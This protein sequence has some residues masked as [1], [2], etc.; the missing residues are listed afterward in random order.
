M[1]S[2]VYNLSKNALNRLINIRFFYTFSL[3]F[4]AIL[5]TLGYL[6]IGESCH[7]NGQTLML[8]LAMCFTLWF[9]VR[10]NKGSKIGEVLGLALGY[11]LIMYF[12]IRVFIYLIGVPDSKRLLY[13]AFPIKWTYLEINKGLRFVVPALLASFIGLFLANKVLKLDKLFDFNTSKIPDLRKYFTSSLLALLVTY[14]VQ[15]YYFIY[16]G[17]SASTNCT[18]VNVPYKWLIHFFSSDIATFVVL[19]LTS[20][21]YLKTKEKKYFYYLIGLSVIFW[22][23]TILLGSRGGILRLVIYFFLIWAYFSNSF[24]LKIW[25]LSSVLLGFVVLSVLS[26]KVG[27][28]VRVQSYNKCNETKASVVKVE[29]TRSLASGTETREGFIKP[30]VSSLISCQLIGENDKNVAFP[31][32]LSHI[33]DRL[34]LIDIPVGVVALGHI[35]VEKREKYFSIPYAFKSFVNNI[36]PGSPF[37][38]VKYMSSNTLAVVYRGMSEGYIEENF[39]SDVMTFWGAAFNY[40]GWYGGIFFSFVLSFLAVASIYLFK[41]LGTSFA[42][43]LIPVWSWMGI[44]GFYLMNSYDYYLTI[45]VLFIIEISSF[46]VMTFIFLQLMKG[47][48]SLKNSSKA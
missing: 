20:I 32:F 28:W 45:I 21:I 38:E 26:F 9:G 24:K 25:Q 39:Q 27:T 22:F 10:I 40:H 23:F 12:V 41:F 33:F 3:T 35:G 4:S 11:H 16:M 13:I 43:V 1:E 37:P 46:S 19:V 36:V 14:I 48:K 6:Y 5:F 31:R 34:G 47:L 7:F 8:S 17:L 15:S 44:I 29:K 42:F 18:T 2:E 30:D